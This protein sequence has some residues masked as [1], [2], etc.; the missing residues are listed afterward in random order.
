[1]ASCEQGCAGLSVVGGL[2][3][4]GWDVADLAMEPPEVEPVDVFEGRELDLVDVAPGAVTADELGLVQPDR[5][6]RE[7]IDAPIDVKSCTPPV[8]GAEGSR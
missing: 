8:G 5:A 4:G 1:M 6:L 2:E 7:G 3:L